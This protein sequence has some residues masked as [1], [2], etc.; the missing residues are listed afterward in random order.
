MRLVE[1]A[2]IQSGEIWTQSKASTEG[3]CCEDPCRQR[4]LW[5]WGL[6]VMCLLS[7]GMP[8]VANKTL[9]ARKRQRRIPLPVSEG[10]CET[11]IWD[12][13]LELWGSMFLSHPVWG[14]LECSSPRKLIQVGVLGVGEQLMGKGGRC[15]ESK[16]VS[17]FNTLHGPTPWPGGEGKLIR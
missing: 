10:T 12:L 17:S 3:R 14:T 8:K 13:L 1:W 16:T 2:L 6:T 7:H 4:T 15:K 11:L 5:K 9:Q